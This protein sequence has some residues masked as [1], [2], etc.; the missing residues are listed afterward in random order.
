[1]VILKDY[2][3]ICKILIVASEFPPL[4]GGIGNHAYNLASNL[5]SLGYEV[6][7]IADHRDSIADEVKFDKFALEPL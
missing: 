5:V 4:P 7:V 3:M 1:M 2:W 6:T